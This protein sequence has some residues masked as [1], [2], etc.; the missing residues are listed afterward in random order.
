[1]N[2]PQV[3]QVLRLTTLL[4]KRIFLDL[5]AHPSSAPV[6]AFDALLVQSNL[7]LSTSDDLVSALYAPQDPTYV[8]AEILE[9]SK[10]ATALQTQ[11]AVFTDELTSQ[12]VEDATVSTS[13]KKWFDTCVDQILRLCSSAT[14]T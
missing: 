8:Y 5:L 2:P 12:L 9:L 6:A 4:H 13:D 11:L 3:H 1:M 7:L 14:E 10:I